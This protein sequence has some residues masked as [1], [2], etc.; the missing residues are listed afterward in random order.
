MYENLRSSVAIT[1]EQFEAI[2][3]GGLFGAFQGGLI[4][5]LWNPDAI[6]EIGATVGMASLNG[7]WLALFG[8]GILLGIPFVAF[9]SGSVN[10]FVNKVIMLSS[11]STVLQKLLVPLLSRSALGVTLFALGQGYGIVVGLMFWSLFV[12]GWLAI[13]GYPTATPLV[14]PIALFSWATYGGMMG[15]V[16]G[17]VREK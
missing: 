2:V 14:D 10:A 15:L 7:G 3:A 5:Q 12:P 9:V 1:G 6:R 4:L 8:Y 13:L 17:L 16:Y 11:Q